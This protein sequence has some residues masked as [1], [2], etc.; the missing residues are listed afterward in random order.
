MQD[1]QQEFELSYIFIAHDLSVVRHISDRIAVMYLGNIVEIGPAERVY[2]EPRHPYSQALLSAVPRPDPRARLDERIQLTGDIPDADPQAVRLRLPHPVRDRQG[3]LRRRRPAARS[4]RMAASSPVRG[5][6]RL[7]LGWSAGGAGPGVP[8]RARSASAL[9]W[10]STR[11]GSQVT[12]PASDSV[13]V[14]PP[15]PGSDSPRRSRK[16]RRLWSELRP[17][18]S[19]DEVVTTTRSR[20]GTTKMNWPP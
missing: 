13:T 12:G 4:R 3:E 10:A 18:G 11:G 7:R 2:R 15:R 14:R 5:C 16:I 17:R 19:V 20:S 8:L 1:L 6:E 9:C